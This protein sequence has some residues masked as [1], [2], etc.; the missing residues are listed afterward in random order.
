MVELTKARINGCLG[1][2]TYPNREDAEIVSRVE[3]ETRGVKLRVYPCEFGYHFHLTKRPRG[4][5]KNRSKRNR[6]KLYL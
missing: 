6:N 3:C 4:F 1:K 2:N 5:V